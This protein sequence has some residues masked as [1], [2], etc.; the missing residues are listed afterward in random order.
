M[1]RINRE[2]S[3]IGIEIHDLNQYFMPL[4]TEITKLRLALD[5]RNILEIT[6]YGNQMPE[7]IYNEYKKR[8]SEAGEVYD[9]KAREELKA[10]GVQVIG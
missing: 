6:N 2:L 1:D 4:V 7:H 10:R 5:V 3:D 8:A 9:D